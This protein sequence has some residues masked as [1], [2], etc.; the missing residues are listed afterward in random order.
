MKRAVVWKE[1]RKLLAAHYFEFDHEIYNLKEMEGTGVLQWLQQGGGGR[2]V[3]DDDKVAEW[4]LGLGKKRL[5]LSSSFREIV[6]GWNYFPKVLH[7]L[8][9]IS[10]LPPR[11]QA[12]REKTSVWVQ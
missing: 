4:W 10:V 11:P 9:R 12:L 2:K 7:P 6:P 1:G 3:K 5:A 8:P